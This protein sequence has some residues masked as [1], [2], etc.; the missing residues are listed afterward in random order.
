MSKLFGSG[1]AL[2]T[3]GLVVSCGSSG[4]SNCG[5]P[6]NCA[7][8]YPAYARA[9]VGA[10]SLDL[11][12]AGVK[13]KNVNA[14]L[15]SDVTKLHQDYDQITSQTE[16]AQ[17]NLCVMTNANLCDEAN[18]T[19][20][21]QASTIINDRMAVLRTEATTIRDLAAIVADPA[22]TTTAKTMPNN[23][24]RLLSHKRASA[25]RRF[26]TTCK[27]RRTDEES[28]PSPADHRSRVQNGLS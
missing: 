6:Q 24:L 2:I 28:I 22:A 18:R 21:V 7:A 9:V 14:V 25:L 19:R 17:K 8:I 12:A 26:A 10:I 5:K 27:R 4:N 3:I 16:L 13:L 15:A 11:D 20:L 23:G 1:L